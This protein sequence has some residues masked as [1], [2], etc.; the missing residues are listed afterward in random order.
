VRSGNANGREAPVMEV[1]DGN[2]NIS[3]AY[4]TK[5]GA[6]GQEKT[7]KMGFSIL[8]IDKLDCTT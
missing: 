5:A 6:D 3:K 7:K 4:A 2:V 1:V 8:A